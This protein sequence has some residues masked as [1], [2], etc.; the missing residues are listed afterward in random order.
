MGEMSAEVCA[1]ASGV[2]STYFDG[3]QNI[4]DEIE[5]NVKPWPMQM[6]SRVLLVTP[7]THPHLKLKAFLYIHLSHLRPSVLSPL[8]TS[9]A[10][11]VRCLD[12]TSPHPLPHLLSSLLP[13]YLHFP[14]NNPSHLYNNNDLPRRIPQKASIQHHVSQDQDHL[15]F[16][17]RQGEHPAHENRGRTIIIITRTQ[18]PRSRKAHCGR[19][20]LEEDEHWFGS[21]SWNDALRHAIT[22]MIPV[23]IIGVVSARI[24]KNSKIHTQRGA[25]R[26]SPT[27]PRDLVLLLGAPSPRP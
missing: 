27:A 12:R 23:I 26:A 2:T 3:L 13:L 8:L 20:R 1:M 25:F 10:V 9:S 22:M 24:E 7:L 15:P 14:Y 5:R 4:S 16:L 19:R 11:L 21:C 6:Q 17:S 18:Q